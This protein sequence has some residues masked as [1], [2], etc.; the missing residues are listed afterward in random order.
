MWSYSVADLGL[1]PLSRDTY[2]CCL[3]FDAGPL[4]GVPR[5]PWLRPTRLDSWLPPVPGLVNKATRDS[6]RGS[7]SV[8]AWKVLRHGYP[9]WDDGSGWLISY[10]STEFFFR[11]VIELPLRGSPFLLILTSTCCC[12]AF[13]FF[14]VCWV[15]SGG[16]FQCTF[17]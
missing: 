17:I 5:G 12:P 11:L 7:P 15:E 3:R 1:F 8:L 10:G 13:S 6:F 16:V 14:P 4:C 2:C 9:G